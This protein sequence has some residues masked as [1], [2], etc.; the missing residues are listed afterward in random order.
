MNPS[1]FRIAQELGIKT[2]ELLSLIFLDFLRSK[3][4]EDDKQQIELIKEDLKKALVDEWIASKQYFIDSKNFGENFGKNSSKQKKP[5]AFEKEKDEQI[6]KIKNELEKHGKEEA[7][8][9]KILITLFNYLGEC[10]PS[11]KQ[12][13]KT[14]KQTD[15]NILR[16]NL[17]DELKAVKD[18]KA[19]LK[20]LKNNGFSGGIVFDSINSILSEEL[21]HVEDLKKFLY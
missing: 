17:K 20:K 4:M 2:E 18:Y 10:L 3:L 21:E 15:T 5:G 16:R 7:L 9:A 1:F 8:H 11:H 12:T 6:L 13:T 14:S 19:I